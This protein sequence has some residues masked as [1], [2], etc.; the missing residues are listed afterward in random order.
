[1]NVPE[2]HGSNDPLLSYTTRLHPLEAHTTTRQP[3]DTTPYINETSE[4]GVKTEIKTETK[5]FDNI[6]LCAY[7]FFIKISSKWLILTTDHTNIVRSYHYKT[8]Y[9]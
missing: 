8:Y 4:N 7:F 9:C 1:M 2:Y 3:I 5:D 6:N